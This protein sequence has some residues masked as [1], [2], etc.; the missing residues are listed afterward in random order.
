MLP[1]RTIDFAN[2]E[3]V[4]W[5][6]RI[7]ELV[8]QT[9]RSHEQI[10]D[11]KRTWKEWVETILSPNHKL[12]KKFL[13]Q[14]WIDSGLERG[15]EGVKAEFQVRNAIPSGKAL[16]N[17][18]RETEEALDELQPLNEGIHRTDDL[19][20]EIVYRLYGLTEDEIAVIEAS[21]TGA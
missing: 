4:A 19:I 6:D 11:I 2:S 16:Q 5:H 8:E 12:T 3:D 20:N 17:L 10:T 7:V 9:L 21:P 14:G 15:W 18:R 1:I 13:E